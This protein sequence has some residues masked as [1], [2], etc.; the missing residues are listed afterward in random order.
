M[1][2]PNNRQKSITL[3]PQTELIDTY[4]GL[5]GLHPSASNIIIRRTYRQLSKKYHPDTTELP[6]NVATVKFQRLNEAYAVLSSPEARSLYDLKIGYSRLNVIQAPSWSEPDS[7][8][9][10]KTAYLDPT[11]RPLSSG[12][13]FVLVLLG[14]TFV[15]CL[16]LVAVVAYLRG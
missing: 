12:E 3:P 4:Y 6:P 8:Q 14:L 10:S 1:V 15:G 13:I 16:I 7:E 11:D 2:N 9:Y 5:M